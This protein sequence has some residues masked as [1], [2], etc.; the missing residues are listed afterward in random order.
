MSGSW[1][2]Y[3]VLFLILAHFVVGFAFLVKKLSGPVKEKQPIE[4]EETAEV[5]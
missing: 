1:G 3:I 4:E 2:T 5:R